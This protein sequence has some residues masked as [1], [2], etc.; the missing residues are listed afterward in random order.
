[1]KKLYVLLIVL[2][3]LAFIF[4][5][6]FFAAAADYKAEYKLSTVLARPMPW[7]IA[8]ERWAEL[9]R[10]RT[11]GRINIKV[12]PGTSLVS[13]D[14]TKEYTAI[15]QGAPLSRFC[16]WRKSAAAKA[17]EKLAPSGL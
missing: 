11:G 15:R 7:G 2:S 10:E 13:G 5:V 6:P 14:Q 1:M 17:I 12:Y 9:V 3:A 16:L 4:S 8:G